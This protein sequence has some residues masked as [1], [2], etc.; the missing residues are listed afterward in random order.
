MSA[1]KPGKR[2]RKPSERAIQ[3]A[4]IAKW[5]RIGNAHRWS[6]MGRTAL[7]TLG[8]TTAVFLPLLDQPATEGKVPIFVVNDIEVKP[9]EVKQPITTGHTF[10]QHEA[11]PTYVRFGDSAGIN[12][13]PIRSNQWHRPV[14]NRA[15]D[16]LWVIPE[17]DLRLQLTGPV[18][19]DCVANVNCGANF[20]LSS[21]DFNLGGVQ[22]ILQL[23]GDIW[24]APDEGVCDSIPVNRRPAL[25]C[26]LVPLSNGEPTLC[27]WLRRSEAEEESPKDGQTP[28]ALDVRWTEMIGNEC[29]FE[30]D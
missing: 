3:G 5:H 20:I 14:F 27:L 16:I 13:V 4:A 21:S 26:T 15:D 17:Q 7:L 25:Q 2:I 28:I 6:R 9:G 22:H 8:V 11:A 19:G 18:Q 23:R 12:W 29:V 30:R 1:I 10:V 24:T